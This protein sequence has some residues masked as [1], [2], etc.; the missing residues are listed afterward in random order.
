MPIIP[1]FK[2]INKNIDDELFMRV[3]ESNPDSNKEEKS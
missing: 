1:T 2:K 3:K